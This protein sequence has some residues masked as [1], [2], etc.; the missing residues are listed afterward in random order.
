MMKKLQNTIENYRDN[1]EQVVKDFT[2]ALRV[3]KFPDMEEIEDEYKKAKRLINELEKKCDAKLE[4]FP[5]EE[6]EFDYAYEYA[7]DYRYALDEERERFERN[8]AYY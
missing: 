3:I 6:V 5:E 1:L 8:I 4:E 2:F 7:S